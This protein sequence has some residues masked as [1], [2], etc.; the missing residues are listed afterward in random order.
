[1]SWIECRDAAETLR[2]YLWGT[3]VSTSAYMAGVPCEATSP[4]DRKPLQRNNVMPE[5]PVII[6]VKNADYILLGSPSTR[7]LVTW[8]T[9]VFQI[10]AINQDPSDATVDM[11]CIFKV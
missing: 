5:K 9:L 4:E 3:M 2:Q 11:R 10:Y 7:D 6:T 1:M 8:E